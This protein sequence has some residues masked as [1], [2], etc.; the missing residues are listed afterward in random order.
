VH[1]CHGE[2]ESG[3][4][5]VAQIAALE[6]LNSRGTVICIDFESSAEEVISR[7]KLLGA[8]PETIAERFK[9]VSP[10]IFLRPG[11]T[12]VL[13]AP[14][15]EH[16][17]AVLDGMA[18]SLRLYGASSNDAD[19]VTAWGRKLPAASPARPAPRWSVST[20]SR[21]P[22]TAGGGSRSEALPASVSGSA[23]YWGGTGMM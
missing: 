7:L 17:L 14:E 20:T 22:R 10:E 6:V 18:E 12:V 4:S 16:A 2:S 23:R 15:R 9:Y 11:P 3:K 13:Q 5:W 1:W 8:S 19:D 21:S